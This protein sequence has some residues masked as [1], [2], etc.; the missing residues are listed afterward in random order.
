MDEIIIGVLYAI[1]GVVR[2]WYRSEDIYANFTDFH[3][4]STQQV[5][6]TQIT[7]VC[8]LGLFV[9]LLW[10]LDILWI[11]LEVYFVG[12]ATEIWE[13][14]QR[15]NHLPITQPAPPKATATSAEARSP[16]PPYNSGGGN[17][18]VV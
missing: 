3:K 15:A 6:R 18:V 13:E 16:P 12:L 9:A 2:L 5:R 10:P 4:A 1:I 17:T 8:V 11:V 14:E 7:V